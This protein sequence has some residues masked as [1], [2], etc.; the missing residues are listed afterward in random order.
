M[1]VQ[2]QQGIFLTFPPCELS[3]KLPVWSGCLWCV[4]GL[5]SSEKRPGGAPECVCTCV[6]DCEHVF[7]KHRAHIQHLCLGCVCEVRGHSPIKS[8][9]CECWTFQAALH[10]SLRTS[11]A[12]SQLRNNT[13]HSLHSLYALQCET[14]T[15]DLLPLV[16]I[17]NAGNITV[18]SSEDAQAC[19]N[20]VI[21]KWSLLTVQ[22]LL[23][24]VFCPVLSLHCGGSSCVFGKFGSD[25]FQLVEFKR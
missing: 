23:H 11:A 17:Y 10:V 12:P 8:G 20:R 21:H 7:S 1:E 13:L 5:S 15:Q 14:H 19:L 18:W 2:H 16:T 25:N 3:L 22:Q 9:A 4:T 24:V 6:Y